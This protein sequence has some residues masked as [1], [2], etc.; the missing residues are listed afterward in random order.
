MNSLSRRQFLGSTAT[1]AATLAVASPAAWAGRLGS[2][3]AKPNIVL[4]LADDLGWMD[5][6]CQ[7]SGY[8]HTPAIDQLAREGMRFSDAYAAA[9]VCLPTRASLM[10]GQCPARLHMTAV[11]DR[12][13]G[14]RQLLPP[15]WTNTLA[16][17]QRT[18]AERLKEVG[19]TTAHIGK[20]H[21]GPPEQFWPEHQGFDVNKAG[22]AAGEPKSYFSPYHNP[23]LEDGPD[24]EYLTDRL[25][26]EAQRF[27]I[28]NREKPFFLYMAHY[29]PHAPLAALQSDI[30]P[31]K[32]KSPWNGQGNPTY[33]AMVAALDRSVGQLRQTLEQQGLWENTLVLFLSDNGG[34]NRLYSG[35]QVTSNSPLRDAKATLYEGGIRVPMIVR[36]PGRIKA[37]SLC[38]VPVTTDDILPTLLA[39]A[40]G[41]AQDVDGVN[42]LPLLRGRGGVKREALC[43]HYPHY[44][45][46]DVNPRGAIRMGEWKLLESYEDGALELY[47]LA[48][49]IG[50]QHN[51]APQMAQKAQQLRARL[52][53]WLEQVGAQMPL[54]NP[55]FTPG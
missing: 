48:Q 28:D 10:T 39:A 1:A 16:L 36:W 9:P 26:R 7:G 11:F 13:R 43:W 31:F 22:Y 14:K 20:W 55:A 15:K 50:E 54:P 29:S 44:Y 25:T 18:L 34:V 17:E 42:L 40:G 5:L 19:Y 4:I 51:L 35:E 12:D 21:L 24:G 52:H 8:Y 2:R 38:A 53:W 33:A 32:D 47:N 30:E 41:G 45:Y 3:G 49:D 27:I 6:S 37:G 46:N 23:R